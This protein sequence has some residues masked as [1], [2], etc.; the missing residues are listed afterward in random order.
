MALFPPPNRSGHLVNDAESVRTERATY[1]LSCEIHGVRGHVEFLH[2]KPSGFHA[3]TLWRCTVDNAVSPTSRGSM[4][5]H[6][7]TPLC[8]V[9][10]ATLMIPGHG[11]AEEY[12]TE[13]Y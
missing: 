5:S 12:P 1:P 7:P 8:D 9:C 3:T 13:R 11:G 4:E 2:L 10:M 6:H